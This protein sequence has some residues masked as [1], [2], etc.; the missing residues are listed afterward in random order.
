MPP[1]QRAAFEAERAKRA[2]ELERHVAMFGY[3]S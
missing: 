2:A 3:H 1:D